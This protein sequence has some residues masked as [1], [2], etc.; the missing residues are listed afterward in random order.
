MGE[1]RRPPGRNS[2]P[3]KSSRIHRS[4]SP[5]QSRRKRRRGDSRSPA[6]VIEHT[7]SEVDYPKDQRRRHDRSDCRREEGPVRRVRRAP[8]VEKRVVVSLDKHGLE[9]RRYELERKEY[10]LLA[11]LTNIRKEMIEL[12]GAR[13]KG[14]RK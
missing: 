7:Y 11:E 2:E 5:H 3:S 6:R 4:P 1:K 13:E 10:E 12:E 14:R 8:A 9:M